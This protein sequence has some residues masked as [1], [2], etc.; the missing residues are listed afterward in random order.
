MNILISRIKKLD[1]ILNGAILVVAG[2]SLASLYSSGKDFFYQQLI[3]YII[4]FVAI[5]LVSQL[6]VRPFLNY[7]GTIWGLYL[8]SIILLAA[9]LLFAPKIHGIKGWLVFGPVHFQ[10]VELA[11]LVL[12]ILF[13]WFWAKAHIGIAY[14]SNLAISFAYLAPILALVLLQPDLGSGLILFGLWF[15]YL[16]ISGIKWKHLALALVVFITTGI[17]MW[18]GYLQDYQKERIIG[19]FYPE[20]DPLGISYGVIQS[21]IAIGSAGFWGKGFGQGTQTQL[22]FLPEP[23]TDFI[24]ASFIEEW[25]VFGSLV[26]VIAFMTI[27][28]RIIRIGLISE[29]NFFRFFC[30]GAVVL[31]LLHFILNAGSDLGL[32]PVIGVPFPFLSY[33]GSHILTI[34]LIVGIIQSIVVKS[35]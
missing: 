2:A 34:C 14:F 17:L 5:L 10:M 9:T 16:L 32:V 19:L 7:S 30:L 21:K 18:T 31:F 11:K 1:W 4:G 12:I 20:R 15:G 28:I 24:F 25:G 23:Q 3:W 26:V 6:D 22:K 27:L 35:R 8:I 33:G 29:N 13:S